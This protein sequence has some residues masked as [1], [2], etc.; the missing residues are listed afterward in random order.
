[1]PVTTNSIAKPDLAN[2]PKS[3][4][5]R[6]YDPATW[7]NSFWLDGFPALK[8]GRDW[9]SRLVEII[10][11]W[12][13]LAMTTNQTLFRQLL[14]TGVLD[15]RLRSF[16]SQGRSVSEVYETLYNEAATQAARIF[17]TVHARWP[18]EGRVSQEASALLTELEPLVKDVRRISKAM[19]GMGAFTKIPN[20]PI[21]PQTIEK[22]LSEPETGEAGRG[23]SPAGT[24]PVIHPNITLV[25]SD[26]HY[27]QTVEGYLLG[28]QK[29]V[30]KLNDLRRI[31]SVNSLFVSR[32]DRVVDPMIEEALKG[33]D[34]AGSDPNILNILKLLLGK[35][36][37][38]QAK[39]VA[40]MFEA[41]FLGA[42]FHDP[43]GIYADAEGKSF[44]EMIDRLRALFKELKGLGAQPQRLL[45]A[46]SGVKSDQPYSPLLYVLPFLGPWSANTM[47]EG[48]LEALSRFTA[49]LS[50]AEA[51]A[52]KKRNLMREPLPAIPT[53]AKEW[54][55]A[56]LM[57]AQERKDNGVA[58]VTPDRILREVQDLVL[59]PQ[60]TS[61]RQIC[62]TLRDKGAASFTADEQATL[63]A[64]QTKLQNV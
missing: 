58:E 2:L 52:L 4:V 51:A 38:A 15:E 62:D 27:L 41:I 34:P 6:L 57:T 23:Q 63:Q 59:R 5:M 43:E 26:R 47:P 45:I 22:A 29:R 9:Q 55:K 37:V 28:L 14:E 39:K 60:G 54:D 35:T 19:E 16:K 12:G 42:A 8:E 17:E 48:T 1:M 31:H 24:V 44:V 56:L 36:A 61:L 11:V 20:L 7:G 18:W 30:K 33:S 53:Q 49:G 46:S 64:I 10:E 3:S 50:D 13:G 25:F 32:V 21:G 40:Q